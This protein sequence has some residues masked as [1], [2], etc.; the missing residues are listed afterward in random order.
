MFRSME[1]L[2][3]V[4]NLQTVYTLRNFMKNPRKC[5]KPQHLHRIVLGAEQVTGSPTCQVHALL[6]VFERNCFANFNHQIAKIRFSNQ[7][8]QI[9]DAL[10]LLFAL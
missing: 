6:G 8:F 3:S 9:S 4:I 7:V 10:V 5:R 2:G 1:P